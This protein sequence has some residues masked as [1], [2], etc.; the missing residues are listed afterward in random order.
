MQSNRQ[1]HLYLNDS[2][3]PTHIIKENKLMSTIKR[4]T[5]NVNGDITNKHAP[6]I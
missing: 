2:C 1:L 4:E 6:A 5:R 3:V